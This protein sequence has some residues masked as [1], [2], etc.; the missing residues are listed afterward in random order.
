MSTKNPRINVVLEKSL[1]RTIERLANRDGTSLS[2]KVRDLIREAL[3]YS[4]DVLLTRIAE[5]R[6]KTFNRKKALTHQEI[7]S[8]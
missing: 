7:T 4:E 2:L 8:E 6:A 3:E 1:F 5:Q